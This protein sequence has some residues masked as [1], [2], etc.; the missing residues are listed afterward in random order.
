MV[1][2]NQAW[3]LDQALDAAPHLEP[4][5]PAWLEEPLRA[6]RPWPEWHTLKAHTPIPL[7]AGE[8]IVGDE[9]FDTALQERALSIVQPDV[10]KW[11][12]ISSC[13]P[14][15]R[16]ILKAGLRYC[17][18]YLGGGIGLLASGHLLAAAGGD[19]ALEVDANP[20]PLRSLLC[21]PLETVEAGHVTLTSEP[22]LGLAPELETLERYAVAH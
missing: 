8:N 20:N 2:A 18:H 5:N 11:G 14:L 22:G 4:F 9:A 16:R 19:G 10:A 3:T 21:G 1:D 17:P 12:G 6:D 7:A 15:A 13:L